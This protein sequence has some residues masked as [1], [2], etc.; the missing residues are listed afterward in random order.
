M[1]CVLSM[2]ALFSKFI[3]AMNLFKW[4]YLFVISQGSPDNRLCNLSLTCILELCKGVSCLAEQEESG[5][6]VSPQ[7]NKLIKTCF[8]LFKFGLRAQTSVL[9][10]V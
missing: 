3:A 2:C 1:I 10:R 4:K 9:A 5:C 8:L 6:Q 7:N